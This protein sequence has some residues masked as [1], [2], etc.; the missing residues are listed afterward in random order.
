MAKSG[1]ISTSEFYCTCCGSRGIPIA[2]KAGRQREAGHLKKLYCLNCKREVNF[3]EVRPFSDDYEYED[4]LLEFKY[5]N[6]N[7]EGLRKMTYRQFRHEVMLAGGCI[8][9]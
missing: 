2:R 4:F 7:E 6:F 1:K 3:A 5:G 8:E 9:D